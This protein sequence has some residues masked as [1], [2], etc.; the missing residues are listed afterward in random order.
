MNK[1]PRIP[2]RERS[3]A[4]SMTDFD[5]QNTGLH[6]LL[7]D[8]I[9]ASHDELLWTEFV[10][11]SQPVIAGT[12]IK[13]IR[14]WARP[15][16]SLE[17]DLTQE[18]Y[19]K[20]FADNAQALR[21]FVCHE[22][23]ALYG[24]L[25]VVACNVVHDHFRCAYSQKRG[26][27]RQDETIDQAE[28]ASKMEGADRITTRRR[29]SGKVTATAISLGDDLQRRIMLRQI[30]ACLRSQLPVT[31]FSRDYTIFW[32]H[33]GKGLTAKAISCSRSIGLTVK[34]VESALLRLSR[35]VRAKMVSRA[36]QQDL[37][38]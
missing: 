38:L 20:L 13:T 12:V 29:R 21:K 28:L 11:R 1:R 4:M 7:Q 3:V 30:D 33:Y 37:S 23:N 26:G 2:G 8:C 9:Q 22:E 5:S 18:T 19:L 31:T 35:L 17:E 10:Q 14:R 16:L 32:L 27:G 34:G 25:K 24:F 6:C 36:L 15:T